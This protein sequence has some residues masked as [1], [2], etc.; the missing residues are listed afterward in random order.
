MRVL[1][2]GGAGF[3]GFK[4]VKRL[5]SAGHE[6]A[7]LDN[8][9]PQVHG[10]KPAPALIERE[11]RFVRG[12]V[13]D[14]AA[15]RAL[16]PVDAIVHLAAETG[17]GQSLDEIERYVSTNIGGTAVLLD[18]VRESGAHRVVVASS[19]AI[20][21][22]GLHRC[23]EHDLVSPP[24][25]RREDL[26]AGDFEARCPVCQRATAPVATREDT[27]PN[28]ASVYGTTKL[29]QELL[30]R[31]ACDAAGVEHVTLRFQNV[32][33]PGQS[34]KNPYTG[35]LSI[36][37][38]QIEQGRTLDVYED[39]R[40]IRDFVYVDDVVTALFDGVG[41]A[42]LA[43]EVLNVGTGR[44]TTLLDIVAAFSAVLGRDVPFEIT[45]HFRPGD[46]RYAFAD[47]AR[48]RQAM[49]YDCSTR[50]EDGLR[51]FV[52]WAKESL[53]GGHA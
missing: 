15:W 28:P 6:V 8:L 23:E 13:R 22:E 12:D 53:V 52:G 36:W 3:I 21:G 26:S 49:G 1:V 39:G 38:S 35:I 31:Q 9:H 42:A 25:R 11:T 16:F 24:P 50:L 10:D 47:T 20:Y 2:S 30:V 40:V 17:T 29:A 51:A 5:L 14:A 33:G 46:I 41:R 43:G 18:S 19:R 44:A 27:S 37:A 7:V 45:G 48:A 34:L 32:Y 4:L